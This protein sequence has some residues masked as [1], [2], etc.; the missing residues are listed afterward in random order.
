M[1]ALTN[2]TL[3]ALATFLLAVAGAAAHPEHGLEL[4]EFPG[5]GVGAGDVHARI[6]GGLAA[7]RQNVRLVGKATITN[8]SGAGIGGGSQTSPPTGTTPT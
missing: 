3:A 7:K 6:A 4:E 8:P 5:E 1:H 2:L